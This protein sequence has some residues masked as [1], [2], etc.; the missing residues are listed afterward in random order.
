M[1]Q[2]TPKRV[3][4][5]V[6]EPGEFRELLKLADALTKRDTE[7]CTFIFC[8]PDYVAYG[9]HSDICAER[10]YRSIL[11]NPMFTTSEIP[12]YL[13]DAFQNDYIPT[14]KS[15]EVMD[16]KVGLPSKLLRTPHSRSTVMWRLRAL[17][18]GSLYFFVK[19]FRPKSR[20]ASI[21]GAIQGIRPAAQKF[22]AMKHFV[23]AVCDWERIDVIIYGQDYAGS[24]NSVTS[25]VANKVLNIPVITLP[26]AMGTTKELNEALFYYPAY[27]ADANKLSRHVAK[28]YPRWVNVY[29][30][31]RLLRLP[32]WEIIAAEIEGANAPYPWLPYSGASSYLAP[33]KQAKD[34]YI[35]AGMDPEL[36]HL[37][38][39]FNDAIWSPNSEV[40][41]EAAKEE[42]LEH[43]QTRN[44]SRGSKGRMVDNLNPYR[45]AEVS[46]RDSGNDFLS[47]LM[48]T[49]VDQYELS[50]K[51]VAASKTTVKGPAKTPAEI[52]IDKEQSEDTKQ[53]DQQ[54]LIIVSWPTNQF[55]RPVPGLE[56]STHEEVSRFWAK[57]IFEAA[58]ESEAMVVVSLHPTLLGDDYSWLEDEFGFVIWSGALS[59]ILPMADLFVSCVSSTLLWAANLAI[60]SINYDTYRYGYRE[61]DE[62]GVIKTV[63][64][65]SDFIE[66]LNRVLSDKEFYQS[67]K[68]GAEETRGY[69]GFFD[70]KSEDR[71]IDTILKIV[72]GKKNSSNKKTLDHESEVETDL[73][74]SELTSRSAAP[75]ES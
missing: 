8:R 1:N 31:K 60:P 14:Q 71:I 58:E 27:R 22:K 38:G 63:S 49:L 57:S 35:K 40:D 72:A 43:F 74:P 13:H 29:K 9:P 11:V 5:I 51:S 3:L 64:K 10:G 50:K 36:I 67:L 21:L 18:T 46:V 41:I 15:L 30:G 37:T 61:F 7:R 32:P 16:A 12:Y 17:G 68:V 54:R 25:L 28:T 56:F 26:F 73:S 42:F 39:S 45:L 70:G 55:S 62:T 52:E 4:F 6:N 75:S 59:D 34:Y 47:A 66:V 69:W 19:R 53:E 23:Y 65:K 33:S 20:T 24:F 48:K 2:Q 44:E